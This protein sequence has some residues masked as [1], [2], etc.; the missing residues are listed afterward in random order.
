MGYNDSYWQWWIN[1]SYLVLDRIEKG[2]KIF[3]PTQKLYELIS[4]LNNTLKSIE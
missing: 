4:R 1:N 2:K 3:K